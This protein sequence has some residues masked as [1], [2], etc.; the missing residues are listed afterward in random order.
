MNIQNVPSESTVPPPTQSSTESGQVL[1]QTGNE[2]AAKTAEKNVRKV[3]EVDWGHADGD[4]GW[5]ERK[6]GQPEN[7]QSTTEP[8]AQ[9]LTDEVQNAGVVGPEHMMH[10]DGESHHKDDVHLEVP[11][12]QASVIE[13]VIKDGQAKEQAEQE[14]IDNI[15]PGVLKNVH[16]G[17]SR[18]MAEAMKNQKFGPLDIEEVMHGGHHVHEGEQQTGP[19]Q[20]G[21]VEKIAHGEDGVHDEHGDSDENKTD[22]TFD[23]EQ[24]LHG[25][26]GHD[27][28]GKPCSEDHKKP[29]LPGGMPPE[30][31]LRQ[32]KNQVEKKPQE[33]VEREPTGL[34]PERL[35]HGD[36]H[37]HDHDPNYKTKNKITYK[38]IINLGL[39]EEQLKGIDLAALL[40]QEK[41]ELNNYEQERKS[42]E[43]GGDTSE[44]EHVKD[45]RKEYLQKIYAKIKHISP[46]TENQEWIEMEDLV[47]DNESEV[48]HEMEL[49]GRTEPKGQRQPYDNILGR[50]GANEEES[51]QPDDQEPEQHGLQTEQNDE[52]PGEQPDL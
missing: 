6:V 18:L 23:P 24:L 8:I 15:R 4:N 11:I 1:Q 39:S 41:N 25:A 5:E 34:D 13:E 43:N 22:S 28:D 21:D 10:A 47:H 14:A 12:E 17:A 50:R 19:V 3:D 16:D 40:E 46:P 31:P 36:D 30:D 7:V 48:E 32:A 37:A 44:W 20:G 9:N 38:D 33:N 51:G 49:W 29:E 35:L 27:C 45:I 26:S 52:Q 42:N 2:N